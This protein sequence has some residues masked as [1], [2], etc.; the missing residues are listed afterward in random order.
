[1][2][3]R[4]QNVV[5]FRINSIETKQFSA[6][7]DL[8]DSKS[9]I[10]FQQRFNFGVDPDLKIVIVLAA[11]RFLQKGIPFLSIEVGC[12][13]EIEPNH[14]TTLYS[15][16][17]KKVVL[18]PGFLGH[19]VMLTIGTTRGVLHAK[20]ENSVMNKL[21]LPTVNVNDVVKEPIEISLDQ[22]D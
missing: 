16:K 17:E 14:W 19:L 3:S 18:E 2:N 22:S 13:F 20:T 5:P 10:K 21:L 4:N 1:M 6:F 15:D 12:N 11:F 9:E 7:E 8:Y